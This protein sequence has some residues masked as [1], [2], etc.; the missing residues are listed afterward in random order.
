MARRSTN[1]GVAPNRI[2][3]RLLTAAFVWLLPAA[4]TADLTGRWH[5]EWLF[6]SI[7]EITQTG[8]NVSFTL[9]SPYASSMFS[10]TVT[11]NQLTTEANDPSRPGCPIRLDA[12]VAAGELSMNGSIYTH[13]T[14]P[15]LAGYAL[16][17]KRCECFDGNSTNGDGCDSECR[18]EP[19]YT[20]SGDPSV[21][22]PLP[23]GS[24]CDDQMA[25]TT[26]KMCAAAVCSGGNPV[27]PP[28]I[29]MTGGWLMRFDFPEDPG[30]PIPSDA[31]YP[32]GFTQRNGDLET[33]SMRGSIN[34]ASGYFALDDVSGNSCGSNRLTG[35]VAADGLTLTGTF[36]APERISFSSCVNFQASVTGT[37]CGGATLDPNEECDDGNDANGDGCSAQCEIEQCFTCSGTPSTCTP[38]PNSTGCDDGNPCTTGDACQA[39]V[40]TATPVACDPCLSCDG[41]G[42]CVAAPRTGCL[43]STAPARTALA[44]RDSSDPASDMLTWNWR[45]GEATDVMDLGDPTQT[46]AYALCVYDES[47]SPPTVLVGV[48]AEQ[49]A[50]PD[51]GCWTSRRNGFTY[52]NSSGAGTGLS[53][54][55]LRA[56]GDGRAKVSV[57]GKGS[58]LDPPT[59]PLS[60]PL[61]VQLQAI[62]LTN[63][64]Q[65][66]FEA[67]YATSGVRVNDNGVF[68]ARATAP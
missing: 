37:R 11:G 29:D 5:F 42:Q 59:A 65:T 62:D 55:D 22:S 41:T 27:P 36:V 12:T 33:G 10:G 67:E 38:Q 25:C 21:C 63:D 31:E 45:K 54:I 18:I 60:L 23:D 4:A 56:K 13:L 32:L 14:C 61:R 17:V 28:C 49:V 51:A 66:C 26:G 9:S 57:R 46:T 39:G 48:V 2:L 16:T 64:L 43:S 52:Y 47:T 1:F 58:V 34:T 3:G 20:C 19:C 44:I 6:S 30:F 50:C 53:R 40:C 7:E 35:T 15:P 68:R 8:S 24:A